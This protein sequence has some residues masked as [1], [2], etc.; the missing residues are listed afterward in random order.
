[1]NFGSSR[2]VVQNT[3]TT[4]TTNLSTSDLRTLLYLVSSHRQEK[5]ES[6][7]PKVKAEGAKETPECRAPNTSNARVVSTV[8]YKESNI[9]ADMVLLDPRGSPLSSWKVKE[10]KE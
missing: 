3:P 6:T 4:A 2:G 7:H 8:T 1:M 5:G 9:A 10:G